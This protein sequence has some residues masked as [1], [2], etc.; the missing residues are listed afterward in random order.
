VLADPD[1]DGL[2]SSYERAHACL[3]GKRDDSLRDPDLDGLAAAMERQRQTD[4]C[5][6]DSDGDG[7]GDG[8]EVR[9]GVE[10]TNDSSAPAAPAVRLQGAPIE[11]TCAAPSGTRQV[12]TA[13]PETQW[14]AVAD[15][16][17]LA[18]AGGGSG[19]GQL[20]ATATCKGLSSGVRT[21]RIAIVGDGAVE[22]LPVRLR[23]GG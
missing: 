4:P 11:L 18:L 14:H 12:E 9:L 3:S 13:T 20:D 15:V 1:R 23:V 16:P 6:F 2:A 21:G 5:R 10:P 22:I 17:W 7:A 19:S 8:D